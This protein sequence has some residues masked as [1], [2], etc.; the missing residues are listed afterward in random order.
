MESSI[1]HRQLGLDPS[2]PRFSL[3]PTFAL[4]SLE[5]LVIGRV[6]RLW[7]T[8]RTRRRRKLVRHVLSLNCHVYLGRVGLPLSAR[9][10]ITGGEI[11]PHMV[12]RH[13][14]EWLRTPWKARDMADDVLKDQEREDGQ[15]LSP[16]DL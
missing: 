13:K 5:I 6:T 10:I 3:W 1:M 7:H 15:I 4:A 11:S 14:S 2:K 9:M 12:R 16:A 8:R